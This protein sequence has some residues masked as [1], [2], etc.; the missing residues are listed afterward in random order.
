MQTA[1]K[2][3][4]LKTAIVNTKNGMALEVASEVKGSQILKIKRELTALQL[5]KKS[6][7]VSVTEKRNSLTYNLNLIKDDCKNES[8]AYIQELSAKYSIKVS[9]KE[10][11]LLLSSPKNFIP[12]LTDSQLI[13]YN[14][15]RLSFTPS[16]IIE[17]ISKYFKA[18]YR[19]QK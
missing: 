19:S 5:S 3:T 18:V 16:L 7:K 15:K 14:E 9:A 2:K 10:L 4:A 8:S 6:L 13:K 1:T 12:Y 17:A 11:F